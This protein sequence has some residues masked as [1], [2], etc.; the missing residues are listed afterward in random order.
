MIRRLQPTALALLTFVLAL[1]LAIVPLD[2]RIA[3]FRPDWVPLLLIYWAIAQPGRF[4]LLSAFVLGLALDVL[5]GSLL[6]RHALALLPVV[7]LAL[8]LRLRIRLALAWQVTVTVVAMLVLYRFLLFWIDGIH[9]HDIPEANVWAPLLSSALLW[10]VVM[11]AL[12]GFGR[13]GMKA[14]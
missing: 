4:G 13:D 10:P 1:A 6:G 14:T 9:Q 7:Y 2:D 12:G 5:T 3:P 11:V 8:K